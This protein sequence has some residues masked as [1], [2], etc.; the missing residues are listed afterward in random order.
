MLL[1]KKSLS[2]PGGFAVLM[3]VY[4][5]DNHLLF[6]KAVASIFNNSLTPNQVIIVFDGPVDTSIENVMKHFKS[7]F[8]RIIKHIRLKSN[9][10][11]ANALN[12]GLMHI[13]YRW[14]VRADADDINLPNRFLILS[15]IINKNPKLDLIGSSILEI[16]S[17]NKILG[18]KHS[19][20]TS[21]EIKKMIKLRSP[22]NHMTVA[23]KLESILKI[24]GYPNIFLKEDYGLWCKFVANKMR[25]ANTKRV[26]V[27]ATAGNDMIKRRGGIKY[28]IS[29]YQIQLL[30]IKLGLNDI[31]SS[32]LIGIL[33]ATIFVSPFFVRKLI[34]VNLLRDNSS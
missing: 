19:P 23:Y 29:E 9:A 20:T 12:E 31:F 3:S 11:L 5:K 30:I 25:F 17:D 18:Y 33:R 27:H 10:G 26:L 14:V 34:Y 32:T 15:K 8:P 21:K 7:K 4:R 2:F 22:F 28:A 6:F 1:R 16:D 13:K 24:G